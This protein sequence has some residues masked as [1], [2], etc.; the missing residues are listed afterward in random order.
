MME[1]SLKIN[2]AFCSSSYELIF[3]QEDI[4]EYCPFCGEL[5]ELKEED[6]D[7]WDN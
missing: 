5:I 1:N 4:P 2:C 3:E 7:N 6:D